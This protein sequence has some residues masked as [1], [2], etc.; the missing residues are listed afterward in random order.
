M[1]IADLNPPAIHH[2]ARYLWAL[3]GRTLL[4]LGK[5]KGLIRVGQRFRL[6]HALRSDPLGPAL[7]TLP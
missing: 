7:H 6:V 3:V 1:T 4:L 2:H 5:R